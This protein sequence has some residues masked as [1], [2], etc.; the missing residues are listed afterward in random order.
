MKEKPA[1]AEAVGRGT[2]ENGFEI[3]SPTVF[4]FGAFRFFFFSREEPRRHVHVR[5]PEGEAKFWLEPDIELAFSRGLSRK[6]LTE[7]E[8][9]V[10]DRA[11]GIILHW[12]KYFRS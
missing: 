7:L 8:N 12:N 9:I 11:D 6:D 10:K 3:V 2:G 1:N 5:S 4:H